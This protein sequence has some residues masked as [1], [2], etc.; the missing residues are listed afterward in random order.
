L[1]HLILWLMIP[2]VR[3]YFGVANW[4]IPFILSFSAPAVF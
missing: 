3:Q 1:L 2:E 4:V